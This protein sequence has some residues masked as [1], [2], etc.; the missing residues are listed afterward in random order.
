MMQKKKQSYPQTDDKTLHQTGAVESALGKVGAKAGG[1]VD[2]VWTTPGRAINSTK[3]K[4]QQVRLRV[5][6]KA[7]DVAE[8]LSERLDPDRPRTETGPKEATDNSTP[9]L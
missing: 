5:S 1:V 4:A 9:H 6:R 2:T 7:R 8:D 3:A